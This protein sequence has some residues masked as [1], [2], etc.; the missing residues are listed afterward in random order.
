MSEKTDEQSKADF[1]FDYITQALGLI[2]IQQGEAAINPGAITD[3]CRA[4][5]EESDDEGWMITLQGGETYHLTDDEM[6][7]LEAT[8][9]ARA[10]T[11][12]EMQKEAIKQNMKSQ[13]EAMAELS[14][15]VA[16][17]MIVG[18]ATNKRFRQ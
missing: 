7:E 4:S 6:S 2:P 14:A 9:R 11:A 8:I 15:S 16:P 13:A 17:G 3:V 1:D 5:V 18:P 10:Q 12:K